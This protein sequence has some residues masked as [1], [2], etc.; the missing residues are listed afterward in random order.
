M[1]SY[2]LKNTVVT[3]MNKAVELPIV[4]PLYGTYQNHGA[5]SAVLKSNPSIR[6]WYL[7]QVM[8]LQCNRKFING[9]TTPNID[10]QQAWWHNQPYLEQKRYEMQYLSGYVNPVFGS[11]CQTVLCSI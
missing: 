11:F 2:W 4:Q 6:N 8:I 9:F 7:N 1:L 5:G 10:I 3:P